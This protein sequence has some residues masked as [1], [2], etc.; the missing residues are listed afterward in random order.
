MS[1]RRDVF[2]VSSL[3]L[4]GDALALGHDLIGGLRLPRPR[5]CNVSFEPETGGD[6]ICRRELDACIGDIESQ[7]GLAPI[8]EDTC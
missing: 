6:C 4:Y 3:S 7:I 8:D 1:D 2:E 5:D